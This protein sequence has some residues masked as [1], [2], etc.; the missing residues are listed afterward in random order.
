MVQKIKLFK[1]GL[2]PAHNWGLDLS[3][4]KLESKKVKRKRETGDL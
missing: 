2:K 1:K 3:K 4:Q